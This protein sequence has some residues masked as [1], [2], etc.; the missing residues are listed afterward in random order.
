VRPDID[1]DFYS[2]LPFPAYV[3]C[4]LPRRVLILVLLSALLAALAA[5]AEV[6]PADPTATLQSGGAPYPFPSKYSAACAT[7]LSPRP[8]RFTMITDSFGS[9]GATLITCATACDDSSA[10]MI[11]STRES[12]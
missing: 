12:R 4:V 3:A 11:P 7:S 10:G 8:E 6:S 5:R 2:D 9:V 1:K